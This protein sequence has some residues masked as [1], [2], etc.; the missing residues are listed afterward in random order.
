VVGSE[1]SEVNV[2]Y[3]WANVMVPCG[4]DLGCHVA[5]LRVIKNWVGFRGGQTHD[6]WGHVASD[7]A[8]LGYHPTCTMFPN[9]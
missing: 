4:P 6:L 9:P 2:M 5:P 3:T 7:L 8:R 1:F